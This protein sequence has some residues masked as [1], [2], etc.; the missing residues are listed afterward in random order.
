MSDEDAK[1][2][3]KLTI[4]LL[5]TGFYNLTGF[6][7]AGSAVP[8]RLNYKLGTE[9]IDSSKSSYWSLKRV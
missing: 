6:Q 3:L 8:S 9:T 5:T 4:S 2:A 1:F 7:E